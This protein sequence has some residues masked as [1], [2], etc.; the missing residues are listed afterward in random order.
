MTDLG[1]TGARDSA[2]GRDL[3]SVTSMFLTGFPIPFKTARDDV[4]LEGML[5]DVDEASGKARK[6]RRIRECDEQGS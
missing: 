2:L 1:M 4:V 6:I 3:E 5:V